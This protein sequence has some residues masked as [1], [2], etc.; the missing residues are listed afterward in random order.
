MAPT[1][2]RKYRLHDREA[3]AEG[4]R[5]VARGQMDLATPAGKD[6]PV[7]VHVNVPVPPVAASVELSD[8]PTSDPRRPSQ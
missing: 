3:A 2:E 7:S 1:S 4:V 6:P 5:R 8:T